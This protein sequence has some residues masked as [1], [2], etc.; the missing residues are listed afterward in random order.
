MFMRTRIA[1]EQL[2]Q[3]QA[4]RAAYQ[5]EHYALRQAL[6][7]IEFTPDGEV[8]QA[9]PPFLNMMGYALDQLLGQHHRVLCEQTFA[10]SREYAEFWRRLRQGQSFSD[11]VLRLTRDGRR[12]WL[13]VSYVPV[14]D[15]GGQVQR[16]VKLASDITQRTLRAQTESSYVRAI[17]RSSAVIEFD[18]QG[19]V[20]K[21]NPNFLQVMG[22]R[23]EEILGRHH[24]LFCLPE[25]AQSQ[26]YQQFWAA[27][28]R[29]EYRAGQFQRL[30]RQG[31]SVWLQATYN[32]LFDAQG[33]LYG[34]VKFAS[35][36][37]LQI[38]QRDLETQAAQLAFDTS[39][40][41]DEHAKRGAAVVQQ[42]VAVVQEIAGELQD[43]AH[44]IGALSAQSEEIGSIVSAI[45][46]IAEQ[47]N[48]LALN[49][50]IEAARA[51]EHG[52]GFAV[53]AEEVRNLARRT[54][55]ATLAIT[56]V[57]GKNRDLARQAVD[58]MQSGTL[59]AEQGVTLASQAGDVILDI[60][61]GAQQVVEVISDFAQTLD[62]HR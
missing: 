2:A 21:A 1:N 44:N 36:I 30:N 33:Q 60:Q 51:G 3:S 31:A 13:D 27:L 20:V 34:V 32:P 62:R 43:V 28:N 58:S 24:R 12:L 16:I 29:G 26:A 59:K 42:T 41:T 18:L 47:T 6:A 45:R 52:R 22:Y 5:A 39:R 35:D 54:S 38:Q 23:L 55:Q 17:D 57:V 61:Q 7:L 40:Q 15:A 37:S 8:V 48:L 9:S 25:E 50:A 56:E 14:L 53:V 4:Q 10:H 11:Q 19:Q 49:A 46:G